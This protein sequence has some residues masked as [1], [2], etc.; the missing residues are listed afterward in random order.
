L[1]EDR[2]YLMKPRMAVRSV[3]T[4]KTNAQIFGKP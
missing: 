3:R 2:K 4:H 1:L